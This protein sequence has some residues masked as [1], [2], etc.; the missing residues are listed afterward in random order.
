VPDFGTPLYFC[1]SQGFISLQSSVGA[2]GRI[3]GGLVFRWRLNRLSHPA[4]LRLSILGGVLRTVS[5][6]A[7]STPATAVAIWL[8]TRVTGMI[9]MIATMSLAAEACPEGGEG[10][11]F[12]GMSRR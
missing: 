11:A 4:L 10:F 6:L 3:I 1:F 5:Y 12:A 2:S 7:L 8:A 9:V